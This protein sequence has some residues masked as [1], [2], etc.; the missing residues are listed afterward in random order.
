MPR[1]LFVFLGAPYIERRR[2]NHS[3]SAALSGVTAAIGGVIANLVVYFALHTLV[4]DVRDAS[5]GPLRLQIPDL[6]TTRLTALGIMFAAL[7]MTFR[8]R[9]SVLHALGICAAL[10]LAVAGVTAVR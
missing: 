10:G 1:F 8:L 4:A 6:A 5:W 9:W 3:V 2:G 7:V